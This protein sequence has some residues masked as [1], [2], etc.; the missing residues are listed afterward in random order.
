MARVPIVSHDVIVLCR[1]IHPSNAPSYVD[2]RPWAH[3]RES[4]CF[5]NVRERVNLE[6]G[7]IQYGWAL[8]QPS[9][10][11]LAGEHHAVYEPQSGPPWIDIT[12][13][14]SGAIRILFLQDEEAVYRNKLV[15]NKR[16]PLVDDGRVIEFL[17]LNGECI[18][19]EN[20]IRSAG[21]L[22]PSA[23][24][25]SE[26]RR[27][28]I[29]SRIDSLRA[30]LNEAYPLPRLYPDDPCFCGSLKNYGDC[31]HHLY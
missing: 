19:V 28:E 18:D 17:R 12:P 9:G 14:K 1:L 24:E 23:R 13:H 2:V 25:R 6:G 8:W 5:E 20:S 15:D 30:E 7:R 4:Q 22:T 29:R 26:Q 27:D 21:H 11:F 3:A 31:R 10:A 16:L